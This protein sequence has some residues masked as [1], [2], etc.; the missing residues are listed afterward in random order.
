MI[1]KMKN[2]LI[3]LILLC[4][5]HQADAQFR[6]WRFVDVEITILS[7]EYLSF[8]PTPGYIHYTYSVKNLGPDTIC[9]SDTFRFSFLTNSF[10]TEDKRLAVGR[11]LFPGD[12]II[13]HDSV[14]FNRTRGGRILFGQEVSYY[15]SRL[16]LCERKLFREKD[17]FLNNNRFIYSL[18]LY[19]VANV[20]QLNTVNLVVY[21]NPNNSGYYHIKSNHHISHIKVWDTRGNL[22]LN[23]SKFNSDEKTL[24]LSNYAPG[25]YILQAETTEGTVTK[26]MV[27]L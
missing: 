27:K 16:N 13:Y 12:S 25:I 10:E 14:F 5:M 26:K 15:E 18:N 2:I 3:T 4:T 17:S 7:P 21:P 11:E 1:K 20:E 23:E 8:H 24:D 19:S 9:D 22:L 6:G